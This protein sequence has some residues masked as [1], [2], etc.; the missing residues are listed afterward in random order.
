L[1]TWHTSICIEKINFCIFGIIWRELSILITVFGGFQFN[2]LRT[3]VFNKD[4]EN[5]P[6]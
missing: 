3:E 5:A 4:L 6:P 1:I 2:S